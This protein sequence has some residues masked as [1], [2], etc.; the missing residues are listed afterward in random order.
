MGPEHVPHQRADRRRS[1]STILVGMLACD[2]TFLGEYDFAPCELPGAHSSRI[3][4]YPG[5]S[6]L[7]GRDGVLLGIEPAGGDP[8]I[9]IFGSSLLAS[10]RGATCAVALPDRATLAV[11][12]KGAAYRV[13]AHDPLEWD[14]ISVGGTAKPVVIEPLELVLFVEHAD[15]SAYGRAG[16]EWKSDRLVWDGLEV[17]DVDG[18]TLRARGFDASQDRIVSFTLDLRTGKSENASHPHPR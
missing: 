9:G 7:G 17:G 13:S 4:W 10:P 18:F 15:I 16:L 2:R 5:A 14:E 12:S 1:W 8:W 11:L 6:S 3:F